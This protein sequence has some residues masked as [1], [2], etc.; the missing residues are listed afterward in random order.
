MAEPNCLLS[1]VPWS[2]NLQEEHSGFKGRGLAPLSPF[3]SPPASWRPTPGGPV[4]PPRPFGPGQRA[5]ETGL[6]SAC[7]TPGPAS[8][9][10][11]SPGVLWG[12][13][14]Q[15]SSLIQAPT[16]PTRLWGLELGEAVPGSG[17]GCA[18]HQLTADG[19]YSSEMAL[20][21]AAINTSVVNV[22][23]CAFFPL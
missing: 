6:G 18:C 19:S 23:G 17:A 22:T 1:P 11:F 8:R 10:S 7:P 5:Q 20:R 15:P 4:V 13:P 14:T 2:E 3:P 9:G 16:S 12:P 21:T